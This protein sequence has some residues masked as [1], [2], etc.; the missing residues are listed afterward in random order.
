[1]PKN[2]AFGPVQI[3]KNNFFEIFL[4]FLGELSTVY[5]LNILNSPLLS[6][7]NPKST[8]FSP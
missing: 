8:N 6:V 7:L 3:T 4:R 1:M 2:K 5:A